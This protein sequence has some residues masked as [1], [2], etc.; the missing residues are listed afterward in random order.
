M[1]K[2]RR[3][4]KRNAAS[5]Q[6]VNVDT[7]AQCSDYVRKEWYELYDDVP[8]EV[9]PRI[10]WSRIPETEIPQ[11]K[12]DAY[13]C[14]D[15]NVFAPTGTFTLRTHTYSP[16]LKGLFEQTGHYCGVFITAYNPHGEIRDHDT[17]VA[18][19]GRLL[20]HLKSLGIPVFDGSG[21]DP[22]GKWPP[23]PSFLALGID[24][25]GAKFIGQQFRQDAIIWVE[26]DAF[27]E[28]V[29]LR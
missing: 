15:Y 9:G 2:K 22:E 18:A 26:D 28:L 14:A 1:P 19:N 3:Y 16:E 23:E 13:N 20:E 27:P 17:N 21:A 10:S 25:K 12:I 24:L 11:S 5:Q 4:P 29:L 8:K 7:N 6:D